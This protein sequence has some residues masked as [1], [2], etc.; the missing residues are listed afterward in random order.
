[1]KLLSK[2][3]AEPP[4]IVNRADNVDARTLS[5]VAAA[6]GSGVDT[7]NDGDGQGEGAQDEVSCVSFFCVATFPPPHPRQFV[8]R[9]ATSM[10]SVLFIRTCLA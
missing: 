10:I 1:M 3:F 7:R 5:S 6:E 2:V 9:P 8:E 4:L